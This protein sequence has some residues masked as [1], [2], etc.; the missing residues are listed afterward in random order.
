MIVAY[1][2]KH[3]VNARRLTESELIGV[4]NRISDILLTQIFLEFQEF[5]VKVNIIYLDNT[6]TM[7]LKNNGKAS[8][9]NRT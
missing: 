4:D 5:K 9:R 3:N 7:K 8:S 1:S 2:T 6:S